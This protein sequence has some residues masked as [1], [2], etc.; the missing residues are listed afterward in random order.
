MASPHIEVVFIYD[1][2]GAPVAGLVPS[3]ATYK[4]DLGANLAQ[5]AITEI[6]GGAYKFTPV[7]VAN[8]AVIYVMATG[9]QPAYIAKFMRPEDFNIDNADVATSSVGAAGIAAVE[10]KV[11]EL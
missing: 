5:P 7:F 3:F 4:D 1:N 8:R 2:S 6:G 10:A 11:D 9:A